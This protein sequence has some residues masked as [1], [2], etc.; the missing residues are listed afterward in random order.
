MCNLPVPVLDTGVA[1]P[2]GPKAEKKR[3]TVYKPL[4]TFCD[5]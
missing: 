5:I 4:Q 1:V 3:R 2:K